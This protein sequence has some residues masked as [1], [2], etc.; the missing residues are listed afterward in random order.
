VGLESVLVDGLV[1]R[2]SPKDSGFRESS[3]SL[4]ANQMKALK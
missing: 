1:M 3:H 4:G 2:R